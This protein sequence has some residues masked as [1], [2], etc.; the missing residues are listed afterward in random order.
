[1][2]SK[3]FISSVIKA[4]LLALIISLAGI[5]LFAVVV[6]FTAP[7]ET[8][9]KTVNQFIKIIAVCIGCFLSVKGNA[10]LIKGAVAGAICTFLTYAV[11][12]LMSGSPL[13]SAEMLIDLLL[14][15]VV[16]GISGIIAVNVR[17]K[18]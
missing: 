12:S 5:L 8:V 1:M 10:G 7:T 18:E 9:I 17:G 14:T 11:F 4:A 3:N 16:G 13:F 6:K 2:E 15:A